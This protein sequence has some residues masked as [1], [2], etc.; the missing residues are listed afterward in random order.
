M[1]QV[2][3]LKNVVAQPVTVPAAGNTLIGEWDVGRFTKLLIEIVNAAQAFDAFI[4]S[5]QVAGS[6]NW[7]PIASAGGDFSTPLSPLLRAVGA[8]VTLAAG[9]T[10][11]L[12]LDT[13]GLSRVRIQASAAVDSATPTVYASAV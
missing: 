2:E 10:A 6:P 9:A 13:R 11:L 4:L 1:S 7:V 5:V 3:A 12:Y 8:P